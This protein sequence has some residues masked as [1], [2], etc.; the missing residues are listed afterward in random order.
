VLVVV[1]DVNCLF[2]IIVVVVIYDL[3]VVV[4]LYC[5]VMIC[6]GWVGVEGCCGEDFVVVG[7]DGLFVLLF[8]VFEVVLLGLLLRV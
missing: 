8:D 3:E 6:D 2:G 7:C 4:C 1:E 5:I